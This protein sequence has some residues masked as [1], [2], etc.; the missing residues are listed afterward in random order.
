MVQLSMTGSTTSAFLHRRMYPNV[1]GSAM[2][3]LGAPAANPSL[4]PNEYPDLNPH[5][6][7]SRVPRGPDLVDGVGDEV[8]VPSQG[9]TGEGDR[10]SVIRAIRLT[11][12][13]TFLPLTEE[14]DRIV[15][16]EQ[17]KQAFRELQK[18]F[19]ELQKICRFEPEVRRIVNEEEQERWNI[20]GDGIL[21]LY[22]LQYLEQRMP[23]IPV[24]HGEEWQYAYWAYCRRLR[25]E[26]LNGWSRFGPFP[27]INDLR[28]RAYQ[29]ILSLQKRL[30]TVGVTY[31][32]WGNRAI[33]YLMKGCGQAPCPWKWNFWATAT[34]EPPKCQ[35][36]N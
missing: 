28:G 30:A 2:P 33:L 18:A 25:G 7:S 22:H 26:G 10:E 35:S 34:V 32:P 36:E 13:L 5:R 31:P 21:M 23:P 4:N 6:A 29:E 12:G 19:L 15:L 1:T 24:I 17:A 8:W 9:Q 16:D 11:Q 14:I 20:Y 27:L 3:A